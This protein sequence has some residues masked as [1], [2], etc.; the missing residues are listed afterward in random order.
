MRLF[1]LILS[2]LC[3]VCSVSHPIAAY[4]ATQKW[5][6]KD[7]HLQRQKLPQTPIPG[8]YK[9]ASRPWE[10][11]AGSFTERRFQALQAAVTDKGGSWTDKEA[12]TIHVSKLTEG[13][14][15]PDTP[16]T[17]LTVSL[18]EPVYLK[19]DNQ[20]IF[21]MTVFQ[22]YERHLFTGIVIMEKRNGKWELLEK[23]KSSAIVN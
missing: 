17:T 10:K 1:I 12:K 20:A 16:A 9:N 7:L 4:I 23:V 14:T 13:L 22:G 5:N 15:T 8:I 21:Y 18:S 19:D 2:I 11:G 6:P 3:S